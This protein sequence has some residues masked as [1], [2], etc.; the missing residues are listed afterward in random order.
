MLCNVIMEIS[1]EDLMTIFYEGF[2]DSLKG[3]LNEEKYK[4]LSLER[5]AY[6]TGDFHAYFGDEHKGIDYMS[7]EETIKEIYDRY[8][9]WRN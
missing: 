5:S 6:I 9:S 4:E 8:I 7:K 1:N 2:D 3:T